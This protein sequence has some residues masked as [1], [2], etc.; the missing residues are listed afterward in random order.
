MSKIRY[1]IES[2]DGI[3]LF[4]GRDFATKEEAE[5]GFEQWKQRFV[6]QGFY[7]SNDNGR[8]PMKDLRSYCKLI[9]V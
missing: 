4:F 6:S 3:T 2:P 1:N 9:E 5:Q 8:I 7:S